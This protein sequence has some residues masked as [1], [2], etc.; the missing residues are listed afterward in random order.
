M[1]IK[2][3]W[4]TIIVGMFITI[5]YRQKDFSSPLIPFWI[6]T[7][8][9]LYTPAVYYIFNGKSYRKFIDSDFALYLNICILSFLIFII[10]LLIKDRFVYRKNIVFKS[11]KS[12]QLIVRYRVSVLFGVDLYLIKYFWDFPLTK[13]IFQKIIVERP[14]V[15]GNIPHYFTYSVFACWIIPSFYFYFLDHYFISKVVN[16]LMLLGIGVLLTIGGNKSTLVYFF[17]F[18]WIYCLK[19]KIDYKIMFMG[20]ISFIIY[21]IMKGGL[22]G[23]VQLTTVLLSGI[24]RFSVTQAAMLINRLAMLREGYIFDEHI[25]RDVYQYVYGVN[26]GSAPTYFV[27]DLIVRYGIY[28]AILFYIAILCLL[29]FVSS[30]LER[31]NKIRMY[32]LWSFFSITYILGQVGISR[33]NFYRPMAIVLNCI[34]LTVLDHGH[35]K[36][37]VILDAE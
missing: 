28:K 25:T 3:L 22:S 5:L 14:D 29:F 13:A 26:N 6:I 36:K 8:L 35:A 21:F 30:R 34:I 16:F 31:Q 18:I 2:F 19:M 4:L 33:Q 15:S 24:R 37:R 32:Q 9:Q 10:A 17:I 23:S 11:K 1:E 20:I 12:R 7:F 27:G